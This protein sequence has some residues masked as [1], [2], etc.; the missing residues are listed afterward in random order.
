VNIF[1]YDLL[2]FLTDRELSEKRVTSSLIDDME[3]S[4]NFDF[5]EHELL[6]EE[7]TVQHSESD[8]KD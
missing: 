5:S 4:Q 6:K 1:N 3:K 2:F 7:N 8:L